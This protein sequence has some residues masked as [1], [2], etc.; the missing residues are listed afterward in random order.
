MYAEPTRKYLG[1]EH[2]NY[3]YYDHKKEVNCSLFYRINNYITYLSYLVISPFDIS[4]K[5]YKRRTN[6]MENTNTNNE[7]YTDDECKLD[8]RFGASVENIAVDSLV[9]TWKLHSEPSQHDTHLC[10]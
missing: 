4:K 10:N 1:E 3:V 2:E 8:D 7:L 9:G 5:L 6:K